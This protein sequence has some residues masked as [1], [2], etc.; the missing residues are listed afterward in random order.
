M[1]FGICDVFFHN[2]HQHVSAGITAF[3]RVM[4]LVQEYSC[5]ELCHHH[6]IIIIIYIIYLYSLRNGLLNVKWTLC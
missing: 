6:S 5:V 1:Q 2:S 3:F 4:F